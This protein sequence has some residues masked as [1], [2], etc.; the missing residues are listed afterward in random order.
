MHI[1]STLFSGAGSIDFVHARSRVLEK[2]D[3]FGKHFV[4]THGTQICHGERPGL[5]LSTLRQ[6]ICS[7]RSRA[8]AVLLSGGRHACHRF[9]DGAKTQSGK[10]CILAEVLHEQRSVY[11]EISVEEA[12]GELDRPDV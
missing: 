2:S 9:R 12:G 5:L 8:K 6:Q 7:P 11:A 10:D 4:T 1:E 3:S